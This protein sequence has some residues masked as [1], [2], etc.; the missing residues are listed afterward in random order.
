M[1]VRYK[2]HWPSDAQALYGVRLADVLAAAAAP[3]P[4]GGSVIARGKS[5]ILRDPVEPIR[6][7]V[8]DVARCGILVVS[9][10]GPERSPITARMGGPLAIAIPDACA[11]R[12]GDRAWVTFLEELEVV[13]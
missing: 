4:V 3:V 5:P 1:Q 11:T 12:L 7:S 8:E 9:H 13:P 10:W 2:V 6:F